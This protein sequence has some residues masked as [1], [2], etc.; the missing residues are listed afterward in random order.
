MSGRD[1]VVVGTSAGG[2]E[3]L[4]ALVG[5]LPADFHGS[6]FVVMHTAADSPGVLAGILDRAGPLPAMYA[7]NRTRF[8]PGHV[9]VAPP[10]MHLLLEPGAI[11]LTR[12]PRENLFR[13]AIDPL[14]RSAAQVYGPRVVGV[15][16][17]G[18][19]DDGTSGL[20]T[21]KRMGGVAVVQDPD[22][23]FMPSMP[24][25]ALAQVE[26]DHTLPL[27][28]MPSLLARL[29]STHIA[30][31]G[32]YGMPEDLHIEVKIAM[33]KNGL[34]AGVMKLGTPSVFTCPE[35]HGSLLQLKENGRTRYRCH[36]GHAYSADSLL[37]DLTES[38]EETLWGAIRS[39]AES[40]MLLRH[41]A[42]HVRESDGSAAERFLL[43]AREAEHRGEL[44]RKAVFDHDIL[45]EE[46]VA[47]APDMTGANA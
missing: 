43:K 40:V 42:E 1:I 36:T 6:V 19:L 21:V 5:G 18:G 2:V 37:V 10:D 39:I 9:Y 34:E 13:P 23:A 8:R 32:G 20:W 24:L 44:V 31:Q 15:I 29:S 47:D 45:S 3:A 28:E 27:A 30:E 33:E 46:K 26:V 41:M 25:N 22:E 7:S 38:V 16:L 4:R 11:R 35:C 17:T 12:G 14:F